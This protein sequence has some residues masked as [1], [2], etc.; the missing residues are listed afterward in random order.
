M[1]VIENGLATW[2][3]SRMGRHTGRGYA[4]SGSNNLRIGWPVTSEIIS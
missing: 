2:C 1:P 4:P 3:I